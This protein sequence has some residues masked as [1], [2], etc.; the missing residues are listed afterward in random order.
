MT[1]KLAMGLRQMGHLLVDFWTEA[2]QSRQRQ[3]WLQGSMSVSELL[4]RQMMH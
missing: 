1:L 3:R 2:R 4:L